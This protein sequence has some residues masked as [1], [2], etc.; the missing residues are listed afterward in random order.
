VFTPTPGGDGFVHTVSAAR[1]LTERSATRR[2]V[3]PEFL[4]RV[5][6]IYNSTPVTQA[7]ARVDAVV[8]AFGGKSKRQAWRYIAQAKREGLIT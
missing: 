3:T 4:S 5:A 2:K 6:E 7:D 8:A 1:K